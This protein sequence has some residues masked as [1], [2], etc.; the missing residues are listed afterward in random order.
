MEIYERLSINNHKSFMPH[1]AIYKVTKDI[2]KV[3]DS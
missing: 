2:L 3:G 1:G